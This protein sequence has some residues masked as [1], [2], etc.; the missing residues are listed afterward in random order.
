MVS[1][2]GCLAPGTLVQDRYSFHTTP[3]TAN[4]Q[5]LKPLSKS[6]STL[7]GTATGLVGFS[8]LELGVVWELPLSCTRLSIKT[9]LVKKP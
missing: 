8:L 5:R 3:P 7:K 6:S 9:R 2:I 1:P 4:S